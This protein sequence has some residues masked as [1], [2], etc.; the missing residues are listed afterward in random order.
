MKLSKLYSRIALISPYAEVALRWLY[1]K[2]VKRLKKFNPNGQSLSVHNS[3]PINFDR[4]KEWLIDQGVKKGSLLVV[5]S[6][7]DS[8]AG[9]GLK[10]NEVIEELRSLIGEE[11]TLAMPCIRLYKELPPPED[12]L[13]ADYSQIVCKYDSRRTP[14]KSGLLPSMLMRENGACVSL[15]PLNTMVAIGPLAASMMEQNLVGDK[16]TPHGPNSS[17]K[18]CVDHNAII[19]AIG[20][21]MIHHLTIAH[22]SDEAYE[23]TPFKDWYHDIQ[24]D[25]IMPDKSVV[26]RILRER[27]PKWG[28]IHDAEM[29]FGKD[30]EKADIMHLAKID[31]VDVGVVN[32][33]D[34]LLF[35]KNQRNKSYPYYKFF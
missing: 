12:W 30:L 21:P 24:F 26:R 5:H 8:I 9:C 19:V 18:F 13:T 14:V 35:M 34:L 7:Y 32:S 22:V 4:I 15:H 25:I 27:K 10:P 6:S 23:S 17:W 29:N 28:M 31:G 16:P 2:N 1:W 20:V 3:A 11:G 33:Q